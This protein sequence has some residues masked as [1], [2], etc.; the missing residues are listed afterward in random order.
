MQ[1]CDLLA[2]YVHNPVEPIRAGAIRALGTLGDPRAIAIVETF[3]SNEPDDAVE[4]AAEA[5][6]R[7]LRQRK[8]LVPD[9]IAQLRETVEKLRKDTEKLTND[10]DDMKKR[11]DAKEKAEEKKDATKTSISSVG[12]AQN[13]SAQD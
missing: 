5:A 6:L 7:E 3:S 10:L 12:T 2:G 9:E 1:V 11:L 13:G 8:E 4:R